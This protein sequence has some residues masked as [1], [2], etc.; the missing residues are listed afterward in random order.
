MPYYRYKARNIANQEVNGMIQAASLD[1]AGSLLVDEGL[2]IVS[3]DEE[4][5]GFWERSL[6]FFN[7]V[8]SKDLVI[9]SRQLSVIVSATIPLV[10][11]LRILIS[12]TESAALKAVI[13][14]VADDVEGGAKLSAALGRHPEVF[15]DFF[16]NIIR[17]GETSGKLDEVLGFLAD[18]QEKDYDLLSKIR[19]ALIYPAFIVTGLVVVGALMMVMVV[20]QLTAVLTESG[21]QL[22]LSTRI[23]I[24]VSDFLVDSW[25]LLLFGLLGLIAGFR[26]AITT[27]RG[28]YYWDTFRL[29]V[30][31]FGK[32]QQRIVFVRFS[33]SLYTLLTG[34]VAL[35]KSLEIVASVVGNVVYRDLILETVKEVEDGNPIASVFSRS[36]RVPMMVSQMMNLGEKTGRLDDILEKLGGF[37][38]REVDNTVT[39]L[40]TLLE[41]AVMVLM[42]IG[43]GLMVSAIIL[44]M[45]NL[46]AAL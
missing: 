16:I 39:N 26:V 6:R 23:L 22:P 4:Q 5:T 35:P 34:G 28:R 38:S 25:W 14:E 13:S 2:T 1:T 27:P 7:R 19:G 30:P 41:P 40:V 36:K 17:S 32:L 21:A 46:A 20:P 37:F 42:G 43:V 3:L 11:G 44:P 10:Q 33:R 15:S 12:Q 8:S 29:S 9:F 45:Y 31:V 24:S 18:Q